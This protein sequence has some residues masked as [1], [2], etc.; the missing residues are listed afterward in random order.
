MIQ[1][2]KASAAKGGTPAARVEQVRRYL[3]LA[4]PSILVAVLSLPV[5]SFPFLTD[6]FN[7][8]HRARGFNLSQLLPDARV[9]LYRPLSREAYFGFLVALGGN[10]PLWGHLL[11]LILA[12]ACVVLV[13]SIARHLGGTHVGLVAGLLFASLGPLPF[14]V[15]WIS[16][17]QDLLAMLFTLVAIRLQLARRTAAAIGLMGAALL[18]KETALFALPG[19]ALLPGVG[20]DWKTVR[21][22]AAYSV[23]L[24]VLWA[25]LNSKARALL[26]GGLA[27]GAGG[28]VGLDNPRFPINLAREAASLVNLPVVKAA[29]PTNLIWAAMAGVVILAG[30]FLLAGLPRKPTPS[31]PGSKILLLGAVLGILPAVLT[32]A[33]SKHWFPYY[34]CFP[35]IGTSLLLSTGV[36]RLGRPYVL[37]ALVVFLLLGI[38]TRGTELGTHVMPTEQNYRLLAGD[39][40]RI[41]ARLHELHRS[42]PDS[43]RLYIAVNAPVARGLQHNLFTVQAPRIWY[44]NSTLLSDHPGRLHPGAG[45]EFLFWVA[46]DAEVFEIILPELRVR[47]PGPRP[48]Y[49]DYQSTLRT[50]AYGLARS[51]QTDRA[52]QIVLRMQE[53]DSLSWAFDRRLAAT[54]LFAAG[55]DAD[56]EKLRRGLPQI[57]KNEALYAVAATLGLEL[58]GLSLDRAAFQAYGLPLEDSESCRF[59]MRYFSDHVQLRQARSMAERLA[60]LVPGDEEAL[61]MIDAINRIPDWEN[62]IPLVEGSPAL[63]R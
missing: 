56:A 42:L 55:R 22:T 17:S 61:A 47:S 23:G 50:F 40:K 21:R 49:E 15:G 45:R 32:A 24:A 36:L 11:N 62:P 9:A 39:L 5:L 31:I 34:A 26:T 58:S 46:K 44:W 2:M 51:G 20:R 35:A 25:A 14:L 48:D 28:Y 57:P 7:F 43:G 53:M 3:P 37:P 29:W 10:H 27:T 59:L 30:G 19:L 41:N 12:I 16:G 18:S 52:V 6:D 4:A 60:R 63:E 1:P 13:T 38:W 54:F 33:S 8:L